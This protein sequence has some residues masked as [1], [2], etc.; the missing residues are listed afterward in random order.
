VFLKKT[1]TIST[2]II[3]TT[4]LPAV[5]AGTVSLAE[6]LP[7]GSAVADKNAVWQKRIAQNPKQASVHLE[8]GK[9]LMN[10]GL[11]DRAISEFERAAQLDPNDSE[12]LIALAEIYS[13]NLDHDKAA[14]YAERAL[15]IQ[16]SS[17]SARIVLL[18][19]LIQRDR[20]DQA[21]RELNRLLT[22]NSRNP[23]V[24]QLAYMVKTRIGDF[25]EASKYLQEAVRLQPGKTDWVLELCRLLESN[26]Q[27]DAAFSQ[28]QTLLARNPNSLEARL[29]LARNLEFY[30]HDYD[31]A[32]IEY[33]RVLEIDGKSPVALAGV[34]RCKA[35]KNNIALRLK[36]AMKSWFGQR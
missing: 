32:I 28:L 34:E 6:N 11:I 9:F 31:Q 16:P 30:R 29:R 8:Y 15:K 1:L 2:L 4:A 27:S 3:C 13:Q 18:T 5:A 19:S 36:Q 10:A 21:E 35:K 14:V 26:G 23:R 17:S 25:N 12:P 24:L 20:I 7:P 22:T 33:G